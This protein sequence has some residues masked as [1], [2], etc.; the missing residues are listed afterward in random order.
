MDSPLRPIDDD[1]AGQDF[2]SSADGDIKINYN[3]VATIVKLASL[4]VPGVVAV[5]GGGFLDDVAGMFSKKETGTGIQVDEHESRGYHI[6]VRL[7]MAYGSDLYSVASK[8]QETVREQVQKMTTKSVARVDVL[9]ESVR[10]AK[11]TIVD[12]DDEPEPLP[13]T[14]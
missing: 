13:E 14:D 12:D 2:A 4:E 3:V 8:V 5:G 6:T 7:V 11:N 10:L 9:I 1:E